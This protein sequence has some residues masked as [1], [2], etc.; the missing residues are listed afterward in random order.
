[1]V[2]VERLTPMATI[3]DTGM[4]PTFTAT[5][6]NNIPN[7]KVGIAYRMSEEVKI[8]TS[9]AEFL[10]QPESTPKPTPMSMARTVAGRIRITEFSSAGKST[11]VTGAL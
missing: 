11:C 2:G 1:V 9:E 8:A 6:I 3:P 4:P 10:F 5:M 7:Q